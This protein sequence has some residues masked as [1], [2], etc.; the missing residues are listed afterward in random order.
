MHETSAN[1]ACCAYVYGKLTGTECENI[2][3][4]AHYVPS[5][6]IR[7]PTYIYILT[8][9]AKKIVKNNLIIFI[10]RFAHARGR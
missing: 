1:C 6:K 8:I 2:R 10:V 5:A 7:P 9:Y 3:V 4:R